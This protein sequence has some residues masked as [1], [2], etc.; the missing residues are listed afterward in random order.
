M[1][2]Y[3]VQSPMG[4]QKDQGKNVKVLFPN[5]RRYKNPLAQMLHKILSLNLN[6]ESQL[7]VQAIIWRTN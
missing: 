7:K 6:K 1:K 2:A 3:R 5:L 4:Y